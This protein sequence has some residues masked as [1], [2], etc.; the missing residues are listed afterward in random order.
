MKNPE[1]INLKFIN[2]FVDNSI[3][4]RNYFPDKFIVE[5]RNC[6]ANVRIGSNVLC[7]IVDLSILT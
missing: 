6:P 1:N 4:I 3:I 2:Y 7:S 5:F